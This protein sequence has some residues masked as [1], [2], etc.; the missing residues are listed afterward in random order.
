MVK[1][2]N[3]QKLSNKNILNSRDYLKN[4]SLKDILFSQFTATQKVFSSAV[5]DVIVVKINFSN[6]SAVSFKLARGINLPSSADQIEPFNPTNYLNVDRWVKYN[7]ST[8]KIH[9]SN[10]ENRIHYAWQARQFE[11]KHER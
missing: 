6:P 10:E 1:E 4:K 2:K 7:D 8:F 11:Q 5:D 3:S 9:Y